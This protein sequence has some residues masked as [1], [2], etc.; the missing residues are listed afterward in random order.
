MPQKDFS[1]VNVSYVCRR[2]R[3]HHAL[4]SGTKA[5]SDA[6]F[7]FG[8]NS[9]GLFKFGTPKEKDA[10]KVTKS[11]TS[12]TATQTSQSAAP[13]NAK[14]SPWFITGDVKVVV[15][16]EVSTNSRSSDFKDVKITL[17][18]K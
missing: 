18:L 14:G 7:K 2:L 13:S 16:V 17:R 10:M 12:E 3:Q 15:E 6:S 11:P 5:A 8:E 1:A 9:S 4:L